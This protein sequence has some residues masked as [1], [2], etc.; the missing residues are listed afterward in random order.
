MKNKVAI[1]SGV[2]GQNDSYLFEFF[3][4]KNTLIHSIKQ[5]SPSINA[6]RIDQLMYFRSIR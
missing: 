3:S 2:T 1:I 5:K 6:S 4:T